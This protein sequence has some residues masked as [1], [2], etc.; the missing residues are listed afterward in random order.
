MSKPQLLEF[1]PALLDGWI[2]YHELPCILLYAFR[3]II[4]INC[5][6]FKERERGIV[7][8]EVK[9]KLN[10]EGAF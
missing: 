1:L 5:R 2:Q 4:Q 3:Q 7:T 8:W 10:L 9:I 6:K